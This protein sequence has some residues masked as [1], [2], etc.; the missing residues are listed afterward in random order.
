MNGVHASL[1]RL[2][3]MSLA[4][5]T[6]V[7]VLS[8]CPPDLYRPPDVEFTA[9]PRYGQGQLT[10]QFTNT[11]VVWTDTK[12][13][14]IWDF[15]DGTS[16]TLESPTHTYTAPGLYSVE[17][18]AVGLTGPTSHRKPDYVIVTTESFAVAVGSSGREQGR[19][20]VATAEHGFAIAGSRLSDQPNTQFFDGL[21]LDVSALGPPHWHTIC[22]KQGPAGD[23][24][25]NDIVR[26]P[27]HDYMM[28]GLSGIAPDTSMRLDLLRSTGKRYGWMDMG[29]G[30]GQDEAFGAWLTA[31]G[32]VVC[33]GDTQR[34]QATTYDA[35]IGEYA[36]DEWNRSTVWQ[37]A[38]RIASSDDYHAAA[39]VPVAAGGY[40]VAG[41]VRA[42]GADNDGFLMWTHPNGTFRTSKRYGD[43]GVDEGVNA[44]LQTGDGG[45]A[46]AGYTEASAKRKMWLL[47]VNQ[48][49]DVQHS[50]TFGEPE[51]HEEAFGI[52]DAGN[53][54]FILVGRSGPEPG[55][56]DFS[57]GYI[58]RSTVDFGRQWALR[59]DASVSLG[60]NLLY[61]VMPSGDGC[62]AACG[63]VDSVHGQYGNGGHDVYLFKFTPAGAGNPSPTTYS[64]P[65]P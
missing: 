29:G 48:N 31:S 63:W 33:V 47:K 49:G 54:T 50:A 9:A 28:A 52:V 14:Y 57:Y 12:M 55:N 2:T 59:L 37:R 38:L 39:V 41:T 46:L 13:L 60:N 45:Y 11:T 19:A 36:L 21:C 25:F 22:N 35:I 40:L 65:S 58:V 61:D 27:N 32:N 6:G 56:L 43:P 3:L 17:L 15:G 7:C 24:W 62:F 4:L 16:S 64:L 53:G 42:A 20:M 44:L 5:M 1:V 34:P 8:G 23:L 30:T 18:I 26:L 10:V 51:T